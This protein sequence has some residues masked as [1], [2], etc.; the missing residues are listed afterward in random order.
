V[1]H[2]DEPLPTPAREAGLLALHLLEDLKESYRDNGDRKKLLSVIIKTVS[3]IQDEFVNLLETDVFIKVGRRHYRPHYVDELCELAFSGIESAF[4]C[5]HV[6]DLL[7]RL[8]FFEWLLEKPDEDNEPW[9]SGSPGVAE[10]FDLHEHKHSF[11][12]ASGAK[13]PF[14]YLLRFHAKK[15]LDFILE[16]LN[17]TAKRNAHSDL[18]SPQRNS[19]VRPI[20]SEPTIEPLTIL[21][22][23][24]TEIEQYCSGRLW[25][26]Y[27][28][29]SVV[30]YLLQSALMAFEN[31]LIDCAEHFESDILEWLYDYVLRNSNSVMPTA[32]L[33]SVA[34]GFPEKVG[35]AALPLLRS[36]A[37]Y[38]LDSGRALQ[39]RG[40][41]ELNW[42]GIDRN[43]YSELYAYERR[44]AALRP[45]RKE[46]LETLVVRLQFS[47]WRDEALA[48]I[49]LLRAS[50][51]NS[52]RMRF[53]FHRIDSRGW[54]PV[55]DKE[56]SRIIF[57][58]EDLESDLEEIQQKTQEE[59]QVISRFS[60][61][62][63]WARKSFER[64]PL[65]NDY[66]ATWGEALV[67][68]REL[69]EKLKTGVAGDLSAMYYG[70]L[71][72]AAAVFMRDHSSDLTEEDILW[73]AELIIPTVMANADT[74]NSLAIADATDHDGAA[75]AAT[76]LPILLD[77]ASEGDEKLT[78]KRL[79]ATALTHA[80]E[81]V[82][83]SAA[84][85]IREH[86]WQRDP[87]FAQN[88]VIGAIEYARFEQNNQAEKRRLYFLKDDA[89][90]IA[91][92]KLQAQKE[93]FRDQ[94]SRGE[95]SNNSDI[96][97][98]GTHSS[99]YILA[100][101][102]MIPD[103]STKP[104]HIALL[105]QMLGLFF[106]A[107]QEQAKHHSDRDDSLE[108]N[109]KVPLN[110]ARRFA[111]YLFHLYETGFDY[112]I[113]Q[114]RIGCDTAPSFMNFLILCVAVEA[115]KENHKEV[116]WQL[117]KELSQ[118]VQEI[119]IEITQHDAEYRRRDD[120]RKLIRGML[121]ADVEWQKIDFENQD[122]AYGK[123]LILEFVANAGNNPDVFEALAKLMY[124]F[125]SIFFES[126]ILI[127]SGHQREEGGT[128]LLSGVNTS[129]FLERSIQRFLQFDR[130]G[131]LPRNM[132]ESCFV[133]LDAIVETGSSRAYYLREHMIHS[134]RIL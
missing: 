94:F 122:I 89:K 65:E 13:G 77:F 111:R 63:M 14:Q 23:D 113:E 100:P 64:E 10:Y 88:C 24:G 69:F 108:I 33:A 54:K 31:W 8:A 28:G 115:E 46:H 22:N 96:I 47:E 109:Y 66:Y 1:L 78:I 110:F 58:P 18:D 21:L 36:P 126:G 17:I 12:P 87:E 52:E 75:A 61:L 19:F 79:I 60:T 92:A 67:E 91:R 72:T 20:S 98:F 37:L 39:E 5:K 123:E 71:V 57:E 101:C 128:R 68:A 32:V 125:P 41:S 34:T 62:F 51:P 124:Y 7:I 42:F 3:A 30:P 131:P 74:D 6:P 59:M 27:R 95:L 73:C 29:H 99:W 112:Y 121:K 119:A 44:T 9:Y 16:L 80:N 106:E 11:F 86:L 90:E 129:F 35:K 116:Y 2:I 82:R 117:W 127:L 70:G 134:R 4:L 38:F 132:H 83:H 84:D 40:G 81:N 103:G 130:T 114:L 133:L 53:L 50:T 49:D 118:K 120:R 104:E 102:L 15:G 43:S 56:N 45:W 48:V 26:A 97:T 76:T 105:S 25:S 93:E 55:A 107:E 85:G